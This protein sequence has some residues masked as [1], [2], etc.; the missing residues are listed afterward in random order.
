VQPPRVRSLPVWATLGLA[1]ACGRQ[2]SSHKVLDGKSL[3]HLEE[4]LAQAT[5]STGQAPAALKPLAWRF[6]ESRPEWRTVASPAVPRLASMTLEQGPAGLRVSLG[7]PQRQQGPLVI[8][9]L[10]VDVQGSLGDWEGVQV[11]ARSKDRFAGVTVAYNVD[12]ANA[13]PGDMLFFLSTDQAAPL[14]NDGS[15]QVYALPLRARADAAPPIALHSIG[16]FFAAPAPAALEI[17]SVTLVPRGASFPEDRGVR[18]LDRGGIA[19]RTL[20]A[21]TPARV[22]YRVAL[23]EAARLDFAL[24]SLADAPVTYRLT[25]RDGGSEPQRL[26]EEA[27]DDAK[28]WRL[29]SVDLSRLAGREVDLTLEATSDRPGAVAL[30]AAP[31]LSGRRADRRPNV[32]F[33][34][35][36]GGGADLMSLYGYPRRTTPFLERLAAETAVFE[37]AYSNSTWTQSST[38]S[39]MTSLQHSVLGGLRRG[40]HSTPVPAAAVTMAEHLHR[41]GYQTAVFTT[42]PN[43]GRVIGLE[44][45]VDL[46]DDNETQHHSTSS[47]ELHERF[48]KFRET[49][50]GGPYWVHFQTTDVHEPN[51][52]VAP[53]AGLFVSKAER[54]QLAKW[55][56]RLFSV[57]FQFF[58]T[59]SIAGFYDLA[60]QKAGIDREAYF[61]VRRGL[62]DETL[63]YQD[64]QLA[65]FVARLKAE[66]EWDDTLLVIAA[67]HGHPAGTFARFGR[68]LVTPQ[69]EPWQGALFDS[70]STRVPLVVSWPGRVPGG[71]RIAQPVSMIDVLPTILDLAGLPQPEVVQGRSLGPLLRGQPLEAR[72]VILEEFRVD[73]K[74]GE[75]VGNIEV[76]DGRWGA[77][78][79][80]GPLPAGADPKRGRHAVPAGG[81]WGA[82]HPFFPEAPRLLLYDLD[83][84]PFALHAVNDQ[85]A[86]LVDHYRQML[87][88]QFEAHRALSGRFKEAGEVA[89][90]PEQLQQL[91]ALGYI[92]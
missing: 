85:H 82:V 19:R 58:G 24:S 14:F 26:L 61:Q 67:D 36:D 10:A 32:I 83:S 1:F 11:R 81:R 64:E 57:A 72:P 22:S 25:A 75:L 86:Q 27:V 69:P 23:P 20:Y 84:D 44:R 71:R 76:V 9:G 8:G 31:I 35:I 66:G 33:Y 49:Y 59:T 29:R 41:A 87:E 77:S 18:E 62:Y 12:E 7:R 17:V 90:T 30:W 53:Y 51:Q 47:S 78:L 63:A 5:V 6:E 50:P 80:I 37:R 89:L 74:S 48:W 68:G 3:L 56:E 73:E 13:L 70:Y 79:E 16:V 15:E 60:L 55:D 54:D 2:G 88:K 92:Q 28:T 39:F 43:S 42:N 40:I 46:V 38:A 21:R 91:R 4:H 65:R 52:P 45:G 34:V